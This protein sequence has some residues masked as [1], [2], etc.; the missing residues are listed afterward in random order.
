[1]RIEIKSLMKNSSSCSMI[2]LLGGLSTMADCHR[3]PWPARIAFNPMTLKRLLPINCYAIIQVCFFCRLYSL[4]IIACKQCLRTC[5]KGK[6]P[7][8]CTLDSVVVPLPVIKTLSKNL[9]V[10]K[11]LRERQAL[12]IQRM[13]RIR[14]TSHIEPPP[15]AKQNNE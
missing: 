1:M 5:H 14:Q 9:E 12:E 13:E 6:S 7:F 3:H 15:N 11:V 2:T 10:I 8:I 4:R